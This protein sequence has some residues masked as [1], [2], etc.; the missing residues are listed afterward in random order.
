M[1]DGAV[2]NQVRQ[3][4]FSW[5]EPNKLFSSRGQLK[6]KQRFNANTVCIVDCAIHK[7]INTNTNEQWKNGKMGVE[8]GDWVTM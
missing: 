7:P 4:V 6:N 2:Q 1:H 5:S 8:A 3:P